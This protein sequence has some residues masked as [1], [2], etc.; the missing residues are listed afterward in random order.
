MFHTPCILFAGGKSSRMGEDKSLLPFGGFSTLTEY[1]YSK[2]SKIFHNVYISTKNPQKFN[3][4]ANFIV[5]APELQNIYAPTAGFISAF[6]NLSQEKIFVLS[7]D[8]PFVE[9]SHIAKL[10]QED[11]EKYDATIAKT[12]DGIQAM[13]GI[14]HRSLLDSFVSMQ[15]N[16]THKLNNLLQSSQTQYIAFEDKKAFLNLNKPHEYKEAL[17]R[18]LA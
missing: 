4:N 18:L 5:D 14:Y 13:C 1:Q 6:L 10:I 2:L 8:T 16:N 3:F 15:D 12:E 11:S 7:V 9:K 17:N